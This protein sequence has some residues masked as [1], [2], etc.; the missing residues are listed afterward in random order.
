MFN[1]QRKNI[2][3]NLKV[4]V[5]QKSHVIVQLGSNAGREFIHL[6]GWLCIFSYAQDN[7]VSVTI[8]TCLMYDES[9]SK[10]A[11]RMYIW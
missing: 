9:R 11:G 2:L 3:H 8:R 10:W 7:C 4:T 1:V 5:M 6:C